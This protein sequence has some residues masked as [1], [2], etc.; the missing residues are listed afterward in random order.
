MNSK[1]ALIFKK[2]RGQWLIA[3][4]SSDPMVDNLM[5]RTHMVLNKKDME[6]V[7]GLFEPWLHHAS[8]EDLIK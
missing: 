6:I 2:D 4:D 8:V 1:P 3:L 5:S 7:I